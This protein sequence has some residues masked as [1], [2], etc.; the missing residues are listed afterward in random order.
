MNTVK[1]IKTL[2]KYIEIDLS[3]FVGKKAQKR[4]VRVGCV[5]VESYNA[6]VAKGY[7]VIFTRLCK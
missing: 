7:I 5:T 4:T 6:L 1:L 2:T 3:A